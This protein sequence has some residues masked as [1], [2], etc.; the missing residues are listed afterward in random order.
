MSGTKLTWEKKAWFLVRNRLPSLISGEVIRSF[1]T[2]ED[3]SGSKNLGIS[4]LTGE[5]VEC[6]TIHE[7]GSIPDQSSH[8]SPL[9]TSSH[10][11]L[12]RWRECHHLATREN[13]SHLDFAID[14]IDGPRKPEYRMPTNQRPGCIPSP[15]QS[16]VRGSELSHRK[17]YT[18][19]PC[20]AP[21]WSPGPRSWRGQSCQS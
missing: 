2:R 4:S 3:N 11:D 17:F 12:T 1:L 8:R 20:P 19:H 18:S 5:D 10:W 13:N 16:P 21:G 7:T 15:G 6:K 9:Q 14:R